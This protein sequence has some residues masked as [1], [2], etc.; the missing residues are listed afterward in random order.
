MR[1]I[2]LGLTLAI[3]TALP[4]AN[5][6]EAADTT[7]LIAEFSGESAPRTRSADELAY[8]FDAVLDSLMPAMGAD[9]IADREKPQQSLERICHR[10][11]RPGA[12]SERAALCTAMAKRLS[13]AAPQPARIWLLRK[14]EPLGSLA[15]LFG[16]QVLIVDVH[17]DAGPE[18][19]PIGLR[20][21]VPGASDVAG[22]SRGA[23]AE[24]DI[25]GPHHLLAQ[26]PVEDAQPLEDSVRC[27]ALFL[28]RFRMCSRV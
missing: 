20:R 26:D 12:E 2:R 28:P 23:N 24:L 4:V 18:N 13:S 3:V 17:V 1:R 27:V 9:T 21:R 10:A 11:G 14:L 15:K 25:S 8:A 19:C 7:A 16:D 5:G 22:A 6:Q